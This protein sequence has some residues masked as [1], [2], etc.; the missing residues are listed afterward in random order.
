MAF[1]NNS[2]NNQRGLD[3]KAM[4]VLEMR[5][6]KRDDRSKDL[7]RKQ[8][9]RETNAMRA[10]L[11]VIDREIERLSVTEKRARGEVVRVDQDLQN[12]VR[13]VLN[14]TKEL[15]GHENRIRELERMLGTKKGA[16]DRLKSMVSRSGNDNTGS[17]V[18]RIR[19]DL[20]QVEQQLESLE[21]KRKRLIADMGQVQEKQHK[22]YEQQEKFSSELSLSENQLKVLTQE[23]DAEKSM[24]GR[25]RARYAS[26]QTDLIK[27]QKEVVE[28]K[29]RLLGAASGI[30]NLEREKQRI[31]AKIKNL[32][33]ELK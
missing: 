16:F 29:N 32:E 18:Q 28:V 12:E 7:K 22:L 30:P 24:F 14:V 27:K 5:K 31:E 17:E 11:A 20:K 26:E 1:S 19:E 3:P 6:K 9:E 8:V 13:D 4:Q 2:F 25:L 23:M 21:N 33:Q 15:S 10:R